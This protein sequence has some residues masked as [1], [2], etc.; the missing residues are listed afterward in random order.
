MVQNGVIREAEQM[1]KLWIHECSR[2]FH[3]RLINNE[4]KEWFGKVMEELLV[5]NFKS[6]A[7][8]E[9][10]FVNN[11]IFFSDVIRRDSGSDE[12]EEIKSV[13]ALLKVLDNQLI[14]YNMDHETK[15][16]LIFFDDCVEHILRVS[17]ILRQPRGNA[18]LIGVGG[19]GKQ[20]LSRLASHLLSYNVF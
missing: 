19:S 11:K 6:K 18:M 1:M 13:D 8:Y 5:R 20:S 16:K 3:D 12:Y 15:M 10:I 2:I 7:T 17:R 14:E 4:D 9:E